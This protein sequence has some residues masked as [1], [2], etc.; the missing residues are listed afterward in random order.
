LPAEATLQVTEHCHHGLIAAGESTA[1]IDVAGS[2]WSCHNCG[3]VLCMSLAGKSM[4]M[5]QYLELKR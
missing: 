4:H 2:A 1:I 5:G 3:I